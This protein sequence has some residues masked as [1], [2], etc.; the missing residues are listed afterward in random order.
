MSNLNKL[1]V[2]ELDKRV[3]D[4]FT[5]W[6]QLPN[7]DLMKGM[8]EG[9][10]IFVEA[11]SQNK[12]ILFVHDSDVDGIGTYLLTYFFFRDHFHYKN[13]EI[14]ITDRKKGYGFLPEYLNRAITPDLVITADNGITSHEACEEANK[15]GIR[16]IITDHHLVD[17]NRGLPAATCIIDP[18]QPGDQFP[19]KHISGTIVYWYFL[20]EVAKIYNLKIDMVQEFLPEMC[21]TTV[22]D[23]MPLV[24]LNRFIVNY[25]N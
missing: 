7:G 5:S 24:G 3:D 2:A 21:L 17:K 11:V 16:T 19:I 20:K 15:R 22:S 23:M 14:I 18:H 9:V 13:F 1:L 12:N 10:S 25:G 4:S 6:D 8:R